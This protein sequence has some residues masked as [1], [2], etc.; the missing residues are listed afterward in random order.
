MREGWREGFRTGRELVFTEHCSEA[1]Y[2]VYTEIGRS[3]SE[4]SSPFL[5]PQS[6]TSFP[7][8]LHQPLS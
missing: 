2:T 5:P 1:S 7:A 4:E 3:R 6:R 8:A